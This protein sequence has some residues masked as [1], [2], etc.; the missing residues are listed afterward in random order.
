MDLLDEVTEHLLGHVE[1]GDDAVLEQADRGDCPRRP[2]DIRFASTPTAWTSPERWSIATTDGSLSTM[3]RPR[4]YERVC[5]ARV[6]RH[7]AGPEPLRYPRAISPE[8]RV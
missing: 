2:A 1:V 5:G 6:H 8:R 3:P 7:V 4:T